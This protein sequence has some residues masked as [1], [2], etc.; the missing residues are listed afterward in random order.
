M[1]YAWDVI[2][3]LRE[4]RKRASEPLSVVEAWAVLSTS[5][6]AGQ[7]VVPTTALVLLSTFEPH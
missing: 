3:P 4:R 7:W 6:N 1:V 2:E 5:E